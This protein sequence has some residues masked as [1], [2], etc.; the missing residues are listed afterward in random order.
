MQ[1]KDENPFLHLIYYFSILRKIKNTLYI[2]K[3]SDIIIEVSYALASKKNIWAISAVG[4]ASGP[5]ICPTFQGRNSDGCHSVHITKKLI[6]QNV[7]R[8]SG[9]THTG[10]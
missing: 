7:A 1:K 2:F 9:A 8:N 4:S 5:V 3:K 10:D 6:L